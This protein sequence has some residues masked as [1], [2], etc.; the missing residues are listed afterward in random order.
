M[1][2]VIETKI[3]GE[4]ISSIAAQEGVSFL[5]IVSF[6]RKPGWKRRVD[7]GLWNVIFLI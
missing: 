1:G 2:R 4:G 6:Q 5:Y 3:L 7:R